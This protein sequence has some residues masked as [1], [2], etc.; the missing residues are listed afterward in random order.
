MALHRRANKGSGRVGFFIWNTILE[1]NEVTILDKS[2]EGILWIKVSAR[3]YDFVSHFCVCYL[4]P[5]GSTRTGI[6]HVSDFFECLL[7]QIYMYRDCAAYN[8][9]GRCGYEPDFIEGVA[10][11]P[12]RDVLDGHGS[13]LLDFLVTS[14]C[15]M[16]N[17]RAG[18]VDENGFTSV[19][20]KGE[21]AVDYPLV[22][23]EQLQYFSDF[24]V[25]RARPIFEDV[26][27]LG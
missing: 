8:I 20:G 12:E 11:V 5:E 21:A 23:H 7:T 27:G 16:L 24:K 4:P 22:P 18:R 25:W 13:Q 10:T 19:S 2:I 26:D 17:G 9:C 15:C 14:A 6:T 1:T 3:N